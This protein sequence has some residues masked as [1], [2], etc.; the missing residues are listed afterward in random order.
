M[1]LLQ[2]LASKVWAMHPGYLRACTQVLIARELQRQGQQDADVVG[3]VSLGSWTDAIDKRSWSGRPHEKR[4]AVDLSRQA[5]GTGYV[6]RGSV[7]MIPVAGML[8]KYANQVNSESGARGT[9]YEKLREAVDA[10]SRDESIRSI[11][12]VIDSPGGYVDGLE[13]FAQRLH[14]VRKAGEEGKGPRL[15]AFID[16]LGASAAYYIASQ[17]QQIAMGPA[18]EA[19]SIGTYT[20]LAD[21]S[22]AYENAGVKVHLVSSGKAKGIGAEGVAIDEDGL[23]VVRA[24]VMKYGDIFRQAVVRGRP[25]LAKSIDALATGE[26]WIDQEAVK[27]GLVDKIVSLD[28]YVAQLNTKHGPRNVRGQ[29]DNTAMQA[30]S[31]RVRIDLGTTGVRAGSREI[32][33]GGSMKT[34]RMLLAGLALS[35]SALALSPQADGGGGTAAGSD[36]GNG[37]DEASGVITMTRDD[38][39][40]YVNKHI[41]AAVDKQVKAAVDGT[42]KQVSADQEKRAQAERKQQRKNSWDM[43]TRL[44]K[45]QGYGTE[46]LAKGKKLLDA[47]ETADT[48]ADTLGRELLAVVADAA[49][50]V[51]TGL[52]IEVGE[53]A[54]DKQVEAYSLAIMEQHVP[55][56]RA[57]F[58]S[59]KVSK[60]QRQAAAEALGYKDEASARQAIRNMRTSGAL[61][62]K[63]SRMA[64]SMVTN[65]QAWA[66]AVRRNSQ[67]Q[68]RV[69]GQMGTSDFPAVLE[70][71][72]TKT[73]RVTQAL[74][75]LTWNRFA[76]RGTVT[77]F[78]DAS[79]VDLANFERLRET[80]E[81]GKPEAITTTD[82]AVKMR[83]RKYTGTFGYSFEMFKNDDLSAF[84]QF[85]RLAAL[86]ASL[87]PEYQA[88]RMITENAL[89]IDGL[90]F[91]HASHGNILTTAALSPTSAEDAMTAYMET[92]ET[93]ADGK[94][95][96]FVLAQPTGILVPTNLWGTAQ[97]IF[98]DAKD[99]TQSTGPEA[100]SNVMAGVLTPTASPLLK[101]NIG[102]G[103]NASN[104]AWYIH[105]DPNVRPILEVAF[106]DGSDTPII[107]TR[108]DSDMF[109]T[110]FNIMTAFAVQWVALENA[111][112]N[113]GA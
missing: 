51:H 59:D 43:F 19:G 6:Q 17:A 100:R 111:K 4:A 64:E 33:K 77:D 76:R 31:G 90:A 30:T 57:A 47:A 71:I 55:E 52:G 38:F 54:R 7:A 5:K 28:A 8:A 40:A 99:W 88:Y 10:A 34:A 96:Q 83:A 110:G 2:T 25:A 94:S 102:T 98:T 20:T 11:L 16:D 49:E 14:N 78:R 3:S 67:A 85:P 66:Q 56:L 53:D 15:Y 104:T 39:E 37:G 62:M 29:Q 22:K 9:S 106:L 95:G 12:L 58:N 73:L 80:P 112:R 18:G 113:P 75:A 101:A 44:A 107:E 13:D 24:S 86:A 23:A 108:P 21:W 27:A 35:S 72:A 79:V 93:R 74:Q 1:K 46:L 36:P 81:F 87:E 45:E 103:A 69:V 63:A 84:V 60:D 26:T 70:N 109:A 105:G 92:R 41:S 65:K 48:P 61:G 68:W 97:R 91:F 32:P 42:L 50:G 89:W 82:K